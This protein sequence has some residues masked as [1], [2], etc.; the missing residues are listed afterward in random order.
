MGCKAVSEGPVKRLSG[1]WKQKCATLLFWSL[2]RLEDMTVVVFVCVKF[3]CSAKLV[4]NFVIWCWT[5]SF[6]IFHVFMLQ[7]C[8]RL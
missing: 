6:W 2:Y 5:M 8:H 7:L 1:N 3:P 4:K